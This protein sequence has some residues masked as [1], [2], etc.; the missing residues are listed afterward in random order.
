MSVCAIDKLRMIAVIM[1]CLSAATPLTSVH[2][3]DTNGDAV[4]DPTPPPLWKSQCVGASRTGPLECSMEQRL[5]LE[6]S[7]QFLARLMIRMPASASVPVFLIQLPLG[8]SL[9]AGLR[10]GVDGIPGESLGFQACDKAGCYVGDTLSGSMRDAMKAGN[11]VS[12]NFEDSAKR[13]RKLDFPLQGFTRAFDAIA[14][15]NPLQPSQ[16]NETSRTGIRWDLDSLPLNEP[17]LASE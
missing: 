8:V 13:P 9:P 11:V 2:A 5:V 6:G 1:A 14:N 7:G 10:L 4:T 15:P 12:I 3:Q 16:I 17:S